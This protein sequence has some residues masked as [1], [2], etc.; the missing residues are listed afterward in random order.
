MSAMLELLPHDI[1]P[2]LESKEFNTSPPDP[3][4]L[5]ASLLK[6]KTNTWLQLGAYCHNESFGREI[7]KLSNGKTN[8]ALEHSSDLSDNQLNQILYLENGLPR[9]VST[10]Q[11]HCRSNLYD[12]QDQALLWKMY[13]FYRKYMPKVQNKRRSSKVRGDGQT[14]STKG[15]AATAIPPWQLEFLKSACPEIMIVAFH[16]IFMEHGKRVGYDIDIPKDL[17]EAIDYEW[18]AGTSASRRSVQALIQVLQASSRYQKSGIKETHTVF[19]KAPLGLGVDDNGESTSSEGKQNNNSVQSDENIMT[20]IRQMTIDLAEASSSLELFLGSEAGLNFPQL[21]KAFTQ[22]LIGQK[23]KPG[24][25]SN[26]RTGGLLGYIPSPDAG[27]SPSTTFTSTMWSPNPVSA[28]PR[29]IADEAKR[30]NISTVDTGPKKRLRTASQFLEYALTGSWPDS[31]LAATTN[32]PSSA[33]TVRAQTKRAKSESPLWS[34]ILSL[35]FFPQSPNKYEAQ[36]ESEL[37]RWISLSGHID[38]PAFADTLV[39]LIKDVYPS[40]QKFLLEQI[41]VQFMCWDETEGQERDSGEMSVYSNVISGNVCQ[42]TKPLPR[43]GFKTAKKAV[44]IIMGALVEL[45]IKPEDNPGHVT[46]GTHRWLDPIEL[47]PAGGIYDQKQETIEDSTV[48]SA[49]VKGKKRKARNLYNRRVSPFYAILSLFKP[50]RVEGRVSGVLYLTEQEIKDRTADRSAQDTPKSEFDSPI[51]KSKAIQKQIA[52]SK[53]VSDVPSSP[54]V[55]KFNTNSQSPSPAPHKATQL[56]TATSKAASPQTGASKTAPTPIVHPQ[57]IQ[58]PIGTLSA[59]SDSAAISRGGSGPNTDYNSL[60]E[61]ESSITSTSTI[62]TGAKSTGNSQSSGSTI[63]ATDPT[64]FSPELMMRLGPE[65][66]EGIIEP[67]AADRALLTKA[68]A[69]RLKRMRQKHT[70]LKKAAEDAGEVYIPVMM[71]QFPGAEIFFD[72]SDTRSTRDMPPNSTRDNTAP[73][74]TSSKAPSQAEMPTITLSNGMDVDANTPQYKLGDIIM[75]DAPDQKELLPQEIQKELQQEQHQQKEQ[76]DQ[77]KELSTE[78]Q[79]LLPEEST[80][81]IAETESEDYEMTEAKDIIEQQSPQL[82]SKKVGVDEDTIMLNSDPTESEIRP[83]EK[84]E[85]EIAS[86]LKVEELSI[87]EN[88]QLAKQVESMR[89]ECHAPF[90]VLLRILQY[91][92]KSNQGMMLDAWIIESLAD[93]VE[94]LQIIYF[95]WML[96]ELIDSSPRPPTLPLKMDQDETLQLEEEI[97]RLFP[98]LLAAPTIGHAPAIAAYNAVNKSLN[99]QVAPRIGA[100]SHPQNLSYWERAKQLLEL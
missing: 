57:P 27:D 30:Q 31:H 5:Y 63:G 1:V 75:D 23:Q 14:R 84:N 66:M 13:L 48:R 20:F 54:A 8:I 91:L 16:D 69:K 59:D 35:T 50:R 85:E 53:I 51:I 83:T 68:Q 81:K 44:D 61:H 39:S 21:R 64:Y 77:R 55:S 79:K 45:V 25:R 100:E 15:A 49:D 7:S 4:H 90:R 87:M 43:I 36:L 19:T 52:A 98:L 3:V 94:P 80:V 74:P 71:G 56:S 2:I 42:L 88:L 58:P 26:K 96:R 41:L 24:E 6:I 72:R 38:G 34:P 82:E 40:D 10:I 32:Q 28:V 37:E 47:I 93:T 29:K 92:T 95:E 99:G 17:V 12:I 97:L 65:V 60:S 33:S 9:I 76:Q 78:G 18:S 73:T 46:R 11:H 22:E 70:K 67:S 89:M 86:Q 62:G